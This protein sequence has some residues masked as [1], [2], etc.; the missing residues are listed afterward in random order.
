MAENFFN[1][2]NISDE[3][4][5]AVKVA[6]A[7]VRPNSK[8]AYG[9][10]LTPE[11]VKKLFDKGPELIK[12]RF[13]KLV[14][15]AFEEECKRIAAEKGRAEA[16]TARVDAEIIRE[17]REME[18]MDAEKTRYENEQIRVKNEQA[19]GAVTDAMLEGLEN[20]L[21]LQQIYIDMGGAG[22]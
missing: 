11:D 7:S 22:V 17:N 13:N 6:G 10:G 15:Y 1:G 19:R 5:N 2:L 3:Q 12:D 20:L 16:E 8:T 18:R 14:D 21:T 4:W 9:T